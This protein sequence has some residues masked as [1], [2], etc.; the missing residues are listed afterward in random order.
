MS[1]EDEIVE[2]P[3]APPESQAESERRPERHQP[4]RQPKAAAVASFVEY[5]SPD[6]RQWRCDMPDKLFADFGITG[7]VETRREALRRLHGD[8]APVKDSWDVI[9]RVYRLAPVIGASKDDL[10][11]WTIEDIAKEANVPVKRI[12]TIIEETK[13][14]WA[15]KSNERELVAR[16]VDAPTT[17]ALGD[18]DEEQIAKLLSKHGFEEIPPNYQRYMARRIVEFQHLLD[19]EQGA[20]LARSALNQELILMEYDRE[21]RRVMAKDRVSRGTEELDKL[22]T[23]RSSLQSTYESTL[24]RLGATQEQNPGYRAKVAFGDSLGFMAKAMQEY[25]ANHDNALVDGLYTAAEIK[26]LMTPT[27]LRPA[28]YRPDLA[29]LVDQWL[30]NFWD[31]NWEGA[32]LPREMHRFLLATFRKASEEFAEGKITE[33]D[34]DEVE[35]GDVEIATDAA[36]GEA[37][38]TTAGGEAATDLSMPAPV[39]APGKARGPRDDRDF[40]GWVS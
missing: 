32:K 19:D 28:Q 30:E 33:M 21:I 3:E 35:A 1:K 25:Y 38:A 24:E 2:A 18:L 10:R 39:A 9:R 5:P 27:A 23:R 20:H 17:E 16:A 12:E 13:V 37:V 15:R 40:G 6:D 26:L 4:R 31:P 8:V 29:L 36:L 22:V 14:Y 34:A 11:E 7:D